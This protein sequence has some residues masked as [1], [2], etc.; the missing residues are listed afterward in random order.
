[1]INANAKV[2]GLAP[3]A[4]ARGMNDTVYFQRPGVDGCVHTV[5]YCVQNVTD[6]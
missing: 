1:M 5:L 2:T 6:M 3:A 4:F